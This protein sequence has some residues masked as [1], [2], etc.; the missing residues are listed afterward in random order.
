MPVTA[1]LIGGGA[2]LAGGLIS[3]IIGKGQRNQGRKIVNGLQYPDESVPGE[4]IQNQN[5]AQQQAATGLPSEQYD[6]AM[7]NIQSNQLSSLQ[8]ANSRRGGLGVISGLNQN[9]DNATLNL[10][11]ADANQS[12]E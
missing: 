7:K 6:Q 4:V 3:G 8:S 11:T 1:A 9:A 10:D 2:Q 12:K 5:L